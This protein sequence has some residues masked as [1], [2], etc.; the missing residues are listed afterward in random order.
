[1]K[2]NFRRLLAMFLSIVMVA[3]MLPAAVFAEDGVETQ[4][5]T[6]VAQ[7]GENKYETVQE[8]LQDAI[9]SNASELKIL[10]DVRE[11]MIDD[12]YL[13]I[14]ANLTI[15]ADAPVKVEFY[16]Q[17]TSY[18]FVVGSNNSNTLTIDEN[19]SFDLTDRVIWL[20]FY[21]NNVD[22]DVKGYLGGYQIWHGADTT[23][24]ASGTLDS[25]GEALVMRRGA[26]MTIDGGKVEANYFNILSGNIVAENATIDCGAFWIANTE[27]YAGEGNVNI[28]LKDST[29]TSTGNLK[30]NTAHADGV[31]IELVNSTAKFVDFDGY[32]ASV[33]DASTTLTVGAGSNLSVS[34]ITG[35]G[36]LV[37]DANNMT[38]GAVAT[39]DANASGF[40]G[41]IEVVSSNL[42]A[43]IV[44]GKIV[45]VE[46]GGLS[47]T[48][49]AEAPFLINNLEELKWFRDTV[50]NVQSDRSNQFLGKYVKLTA[51]IDLSGINWNPI[52]EKK[53]HGSFMGIFDGGD[54]T[55]SNLYV[56]QAGEYLGLFAY[57]GSFSE[58][59][60]AVIKNLTLH[61]VTVKSTDNSN[62]VGGLVGNA[63]TTNF[64]NIHVTGTVEISGRG[65]IGGIVGHGYSDFNNVSVRATNG[66]ISSTFW[67]AG[68]VIGYL[69]E[70]S[71][72]KNAV[73]EGLTIKSAAGGLGSIVGMSSSNDGTQPCTGEN[74]SA[75]NVAIQTYTGA[76]GDG[77]AENG[78]GYLIGGDTS[79]MTGS[80]TVE[81]V[82]FACSNGTTNPDVSD[83]VASVNGTIYFDLQS[84][85]DESNGATVTLLRDATENITIADGA[86]VVI[87][88]G[89]KTL[90]G[91]IAPCN[92]ASLTISNGSIKNTN[93]G[94]SAIEIKAGTLT[95]TNVNIESARHAV[96][97]DGAVTA[98][99]D[100]G[101][102]TLTSTSGT[103]HAINVSG[104]ANVTI[105]AGTFVGPK[106]TAADSGSAVCVQSGAAVTIEGGN[107]SGGK[108]NTLVAAGA[109]TVTGGTFDQDPT[110]YV[111]TGYKAEE[112]EGI[113]SVVK[114][115][116][117]WEVATK[118]ELKAALYAAQDGDTIVLTAD[119]DYG[120]D[121]VTDNDTVST[122]G[123]TKAITLDLGGHTLT[124]HARNFGLALRNDG[125]IVTNGKLNHVGTVAAIKVWDAAEISD[126]EIDV[127]GTSSSGN[128]IDGIVIQENA[129]GVDLIQDVT[130]HS[131]DGQGV[132]SGIK[133][134]NCGNATE[135][136]IGSM[137]S[138]VI[139][140]K[141]VGLNISAPCGTATNCSI[142]GGTNG[143]EIW[144]K[145]TYSAT[146]D[147]VGCDV[148]GGVFA[149][150]EFSSNPSIVNNGTLKLMADTATTGASEDD[151]TLT[152]ARAEKVE[153]ILK[154]VMDNAQAK[155]ND[156]YYATLASAIAAAQNG[157]I[158]TLIWAEG[159]AA[160]A[161][162]GAVYGKTVTITGTATVDWSKGNLFVGRGG[163]GD[164]KV[165]FDGANITSSVKKNPAS[166]GIHVSGDKGSDANTNY[167][168]L[169]IKNS[170]IELDYLINRNATI[171]DGNSTL[172]VYGGCWTHGRDA[173]ESVSGTDETAT[174]TIG[175]GST[176]IVINENG[177]G[178][179]GEGK[180]EMIVD[181][182][183][184]ANVLN[185]SAKGIVKIGG[186][187]AI[188]GTATNNGSIVLTDKAATLTSTECG[189]VTTTLNGC[190]VV[191]ENGVYKV[192]HKAIEVTY[193]DGTVEYFDDILEAVPYKTDY[194]KLQGATIKLLADVTGKGIRFMETGM[195]LDL[196]KHTY[197]IN[198]ATGSSGTNTS[199]F[200]IREDASKT[201]IKNGTIKVA[202]PDD[203]VENTS[204]IWM[205]NSYSAD[206]TVEDVTIDC[207]NMAWG[208]GE[209]CYVHVSRPGDNTNFI[210]TTKVINFNSEVAGN[211]IN[212]GGTM[213]IGEDVVPGG[214][215]ELDDGA[216]LSAP[217]GLPV[218]TTVVGYE[219]KYVDGKYTVVEVEEVEL[220]SGF[221]TVA[222]LGETLSLIFTVPY[223]V[224]AIDNQTDYSATI[225]MTLAN[226]S[227]R[228]ETIDGSDWARHGASQKWWIEFTGIA[229]KEMADNVSIT[230][231]KIVDGKK[232]QFSETYTDSVMKYSDRLL[233]NSTNA[234][235]K[236]MAVDMLCYGAAA[237]IQFNYNTSSLATQLLTDD[238]KSLATATVPTAT[239]DRTTS[240]SSYARGLRMVLESD[241]SMVFTFNN[242]SEG[243]YVIATYKD[244]YGNDKTVRQSEFI[245]YNGYKGFRVSGM[246]VADANQ[247]VTCTL[248]SSTG[249]VLSVVTDS[250]NSY[251]AR[252]IEGSQDDT[253]Y[254]NLLKF[255]QSAY[256][257]LHD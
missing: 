71:T 58:S 205:F 129:A 87:D 68:G 166:T 185:V 154:N 170:T 135:P 249:T 173:S 256:N 145:G 165:I 234:N 131:T 152:I 42:G 207:T 187:V 247:T 104:A 60:Q 3:G 182:T 133:T 128:T 171:V 253:L 223:D 134:Y 184:N 246:A 97:I 202:E 161:M 73:V 48:G 146:L 22:V 91:Y 16:N 230:I 61:N 52:G 174:L 168:T 27:S 254:E 191:Y 122:W 167:G 220:F 89:G 163:E 206:F 56:E 226:G 179:G 64:E 112:N 19:V 210:G 100:G 243:M 215:V 79:V 178:V 244:H 208:Y 144:I 236:T 209:N 74:L 6:Y 109:L 194:D 212:V 103:R 119:I 86:T 45:L 20:G 114:S 222:R 123:I 5:E 34:N 93:A 67:C 211:A 55:I 240:E 250:I 66:T 33:L 7:V 13:V 54:H 183:Y 32:G 140:A 153:G 121:H 8:A 132:D 90:N 28:S 105:K 201:T 216:T 126:L 252:A 143:I 29:L 136:V 199:G 229:A 124:T 157:D 77:Y 239:N 15:T 196:N 188:T 180:G 237:Q 82:T 148:V 62:Y 190:K 164:G 18:D 40:T 115:N 96:R 195:V 92:P 51:D 49:T 127:T 169:E 197:T 106:G 57:T 83:A 231:Y 44:D 110:A 75:K 232:V 85:L 150:D 26:T 189:S 1:M 228:T 108:N 102:Y 255:A 175:A 186:A 151:I 192:A 31:K 176:V 238:E 159:D 149:H 245:S 225:V 172:T 59:E 81:N 39:I 80:N 221:K 113:F 242:I 200:Q 53:D 99:I 160:I 46:A 214:A 248:Y 95:L 24:T 23:V 17:G 193:A 156:T 162:N 204:V 251:C 69:G 25:Y 9:G 198:N 78:L 233:A 38:A 11:K 47:G 76:Y 155:V 2:L 63:T 50:D 257:S 227:T 120:T 10:S 116:T 111:A 65:Y 177:M 139:D 37:I 138:V 142:K 147:L 181:G 213:T 241:L 101:K 141:S 94:Y 36:K 12:F 217:E 41:T 218:T 107:F 125:V 21:G 98:T 14:N 203:M 158:I 35:A 224:I 118:A 84:A 88:L 130:I 219:V 72:I 4:S 137:E 117:I 43:K 70:G 30:S 235:D